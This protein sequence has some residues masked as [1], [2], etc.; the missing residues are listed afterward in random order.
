MFDYVIIARPRAGS[1]MLATALHGHPQL[2]NTGEIGGNRDYLD[3]LLGE[4][5]NT[6][7]GC[8]GKPGMYSDVGKR[9]VLMRGYDE[10]KHSWQ[11]SNYYH[12]ISPW[13]IT[14][15]P[16]YAFTFPEDRG[17]NK[18]NIE[19]ETGL[20]L[21]YDDITGGVDC[22]VIPEKVTQEICDYLGVDTYPLRPLTY[23]PT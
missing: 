1:H 6:L 10:R 2:S 12:R 3:G 11:M 17:E 23:K 19:D 14:G 9:I 20:F 15:K 4:K 21:N 13:Q 18:S 5:E 7:K 22:R 8:I 16:N